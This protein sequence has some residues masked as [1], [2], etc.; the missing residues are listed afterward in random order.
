MLGLSTFLLVS[1]HRTSSPTTVQ[2]VGSGS[3]IGIGRGDGRGVGSLVG[4]CIDRGD[5]SNYDD[6]GSGGGGVDDDGGGGKSLP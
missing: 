5:G 3:S 2:S 6:Y 1:T 4:S